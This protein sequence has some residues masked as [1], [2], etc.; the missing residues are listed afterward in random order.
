MKQVV[1][2]LR[3]G[4]L[5]LMDVPCPGTSRGHLLIESRKSVISAGTERFLVEFGKASLIQKARQNPERVKQVL[6]KI[7][8]DGLLPTLEAVFNKLDEPLPMGYC[9][10]GRVIEVGPG[11]E[12]Y[13]VGDRVASN[14]PHAQLVHVPVHLTAKIADVVTDEEAAFAVL[15]SI[16]LQ[17][18]RLVKPQLGETVA[19]FGLGLVG[20]LSVQMLSAAGCHVIG[21][22]VNPQRLQLAASFGAGKTVNP[23]AGGD[24]VSTAMAATGGHGV[25]AVLI[26][27]SAKNDTIVS[28]SAQMA[29]KRGRIVLVGVVDMQLNRAEFYEKE[30]SFQVSCSYGPGRYDPQYE[31]QG[32][33]Y[34]YP[35]VRWTEQ[36]NIQAVLD[37]MAERKLHLQPLITHRFPLTDAV[38]AYETLSR[39]RSALGVVLQYEPLEEEASVGHSEPSMRKPLSSVRRRTVAT[40]G[41]MSSDYPTLPEQGQVTVGVIGAGAFTK[42]VL[43]PALKKTPARLRAIASAGGLSAAHAAHK[44]GFE[45]STT[46]YQTILEDSQI[47]TVLIT[48]RHHM[49][50]R[51]VVEALEAGKHVFVEKPLAIDREGLESVARAYRDRAEQQHLMVGFNRRFAP[52]IKTMRRLLA[53]RNVPFCATMLVNAGAIAPDHWIQNRQIGG[54]RI[55]GEGCHWI[56]LMCHLAGGTVAHAHAVHLGDVPGV[57]T[58]GDHCVLSLRLSDGSVASIQYFA[59]GSR[60]FPKERLTLFAGGAGL[61]LDNFRRLNGYGWP[62]FRRQRLFRQDKGHQQQLTEFVDRIASGGPPLIPFEQLQSVTQTSL[63]CELALQTPRR[64][65]EPVSC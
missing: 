63:E 65:A 58:R 57:L 17:G 1:Q 59:N 13:Q 11:V 30:L 40:S 37:L 53:G 39:D 28:Q 22:D 24:P 56:D 33:D 42:G 64:E 6:D 18:I 4:V 3:T 14:G 12:G 47:D 8:A 10:A 60:L 61:E 7:R 50:A 20:L 29:R 55:V 5:E 38:G 54:G 2:N 21:I 35:F 49:H 9:N 36:R 44:F 46:D 31:E 16:G 52:H 32:I 45:R 26:T 48:T 62:G 34:P 23:A 43:L 25:D 15:G 27:A 51:L 19:V 41:G